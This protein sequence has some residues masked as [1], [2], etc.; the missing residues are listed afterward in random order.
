VYVFLVHLP[1]EC[2]HEPC[3]AF[4]VALGHAL[5]EAKRPLVYGGGNWGIMGIIAG[6]VMDEGGQVTGVIPYAIHASGGELDKGDGHVKTESIAKALDNK[7]RGQVRD[8]IFI[9]Q[10]MPDL[11][12][13]MAT[14]I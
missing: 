6:A 4:L 10:H 3:P 7:G 11:K 12:T 14:H 13:R 9:L 1:R 2:P 8:L 5:A